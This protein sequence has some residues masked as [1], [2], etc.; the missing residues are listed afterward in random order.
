MNIIHVVCNPSTGVL[1]LI[2]SL[3]S[4]Q[5]KDK[6]KKV[7]ILVIYDKTIN[8]KEVDSNFSNFEIKK[9][10]TPFKINSFFYFFFYLLS[11]FKTLFNEK[12][13]FYHFHNAQM[14]SAFLTKK[15]IN[16]SLITIHGFPSY[17]RFM[18]SSN[19]SVVKKMHYLFFKRIELMQLKLSS[20]D[21]RSIDK[22]KKCFNVDLPFYCI[23]NCCEN[24][25]FGLNKN[26]VVKFTFVGAIDDNKGVEE[27]LEA[28]C[29]VDKDYELHIF[30]S[31]DKLYNLL[32]KYTHKN[33]IIFYGSVQRSEI[34]KLFPKFDVFISFSKTEGFSMSFIEALASGLAIITTNWGDVKDY[35]QGNGF[36]IEREINIL[37]NT[38]TK[39]IEMESNL[40]NEMKMKSVDIFNNKLR[41]SIISSKYM[42]IYEKKI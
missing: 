3:I 14:S 23:P 17:E 21:K 39:L 37:Q 12:D 11:F 19:F 32:N 25:F 29:R 24:N 22:I 16:N 28:F 10:Y 40:L 36:M 13:T 18:N 6:K 33:N 15:N 4:E 1:S 34:L 38:I 31:G 27:I 41:P 30:G 20:V 26:R 5:M 8:I 7:S 2:S 42:D 9:I 35:V